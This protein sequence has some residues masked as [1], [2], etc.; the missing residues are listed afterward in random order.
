MIAGII[1]VIACIAGYL[2]FAGMRDQSEAATEDDLREKMADASVTKIAVKGDLVL[3]APLEVKGTKILY[4]DGSI[5][6]GGDGWAGDEYMIVIPSGAQL[7]VKD[8]V[9]IDADGV[10][11]FLEKILL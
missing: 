10:A 2:I 1:L 9:T 4:G 7:T 5:T 11:G 3:K 6:A 8:A